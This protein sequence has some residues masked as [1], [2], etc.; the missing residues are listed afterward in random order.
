MTSSP[1]LVA[2]QGLLRRN[3]VALRLLLIGFLTLL[4]LSP[5]ALV[6]S[7]LRERVVRHEAEIATITPSWGKSQ[8]LLGPVLVV[9]FT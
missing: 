6:Q 7:T 1:V 3:A 5:F 9:P 2:G 8:R 4:L